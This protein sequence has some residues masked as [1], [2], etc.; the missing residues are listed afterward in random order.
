MSPSVSVRLLS[1]QSDARLLALAQQGHERAF[2]A[3]VQ[4]Y[5]RPLLAYCRRVLLP[6][7]RA[8][9]ALQQGLLQAWL[10]LQ[11]GT[12]VRDAKAWLYRIVHNAALNTLRGSGYDYAEL[13]EALSG[14]AASQEDLDRRIAVREALAGL[15]ALPELQREAL[16]R[17]AVEGHSHGQVAEAMG[18]SEG[19]L[20]GLVYRARAT[21][22]TAVT[23]ITP[24]PLVSWAVGAGS[25]GGT[26]A[27]LAVGGGSA[28]GGDRRSGGSG[29][30]GDST[31]G[32]STGGSSDATP[33]DSRGGTGSDGGGNG[34]DAGAPGSGTSG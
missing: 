26:I 1:T 34:G 2:E 12:E 31:G 24:A 14:A 17:T 22:R 25:H 4:R 15:A 16:L 13:S 11:N 20:R 27:E 9:D 8:E 18:L 7:S 29:G 30:G 28:G 3:L 33:S 19:A 10:A 32:S 6:D 21:L 5:R 23:A